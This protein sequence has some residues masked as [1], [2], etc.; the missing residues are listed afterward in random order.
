MIDLIK[1]KIKGKKILILGYGRE[2]ESTYCFFKKYFPNVKLAIADKNANAFESIK[3]E[4]IKFYSGDRYLEAIPEYDLIFKTPGVS[5]NHVNFKFDKN[6]ITSQTDIFLQCYHR[7]IIG[8]TGTKGKSTTSSLIYHIMKLYTD[9]VL[10]VGNIGV[11]PF[12]VFE[13][14]RSTTCIV[15]ELSSHQLEYIHKAPHISILLSIFQEH[16]DYYKSFEDY[17]QAKF[18]IFRFQEAYDYFIYDA[19]D[20]ASR[21]FIKSQEYADNCYTFSLKNKCN[22]GCYVLDGSIFFSEDGDAYPIYD[23]YQERKLKG[24]HNLLNIMAAICAC[25]LYGIPDNNIIEGVNFFK[26]LEH[27]IEYVGNFNRIDYYNDSIATIPEAT[28][29]AIKTLE[30]VNTVILGGYDRGVD[31]SYLVDYLIK[32]SVKNIIFMGKA[33]ERMYQM[34][35]KKKPNKNLIIADSLEDAVTVAKQ[36]TVKDGICLLS[37]AASSYDSFRNFEERGEVYKKI[38]KSVL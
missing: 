14:I 17:K 12:N 26:G 15:Y 9:D 32:S 11:P 25:K 27:R 22:F 23:I 29:E 38:V 34:I 2:G 35:S 21:E 30:D 7:Q 18:N 13:Q 28:I 5:L 24:S 31:Y 36:K 20:K 8:I 1:E 19:D 3:N 37:P 33:G 4:K 16:L 6:T 10:L